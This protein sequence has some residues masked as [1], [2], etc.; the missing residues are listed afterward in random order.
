MLARGR[1][2]LTRSFAIQVQTVAADTL[3]LETPSPSWA[4]LCA[5]NRMGSQVA[6][7]L[8]LCQVLRPT[9]PA[10]DLLSP[11]CLARYSVKPVLMRRWQPE[12]ARSRSDA[13]LRDASS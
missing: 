2:C 13:D 9:L 5:L 11:G 4:S 1:T 3:Q 7:E 8:V 12:R 6:K 10:A